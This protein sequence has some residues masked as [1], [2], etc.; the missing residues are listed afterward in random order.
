MN[1][2]PTP[3]T[4]Q[5]SRNLAANRAGNGDACHEE[6]TIIDAEF[7]EI[8]PVPDRSV[9]NWEKAGQV[10]GRA[11]IDVAAMTGKGIWLT[12][13]VSGHL[14]YYAVIVMVYVMKGLADVLRELVSMSGRDPGDGLPWMDS[15]PNVNVETNVNVDGPANV[16][17]TN[18]IH[19]K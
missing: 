8:Q 9:V 10:T 7:E 13:V 16:N 18:N 11:V 5:F 14:V 15:R 4:P 3:Q 2:Y 12:M 1:H 19:V 17:V 6:P